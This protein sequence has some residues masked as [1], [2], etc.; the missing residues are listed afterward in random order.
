M[1]DKILERKKKSLQKHIDKTYSYYLTRFKP[2]FLKK[3]NF[4]GNDKDIE[5]RKLI[6]YKSIKLYAEAKTLKDLCKL[7]IQF[8]EKKIYCSSNPTGP[9]HDNLFPKNTWDEILNVDNINIT[10]QLI[11]INKLGIYTL[12]SQNGKKGIYEGVGYNYRM[13]VSGVTT[14]QIAKKIYKYFA[15]HEDT[16]VIS[17]N[18][19]VINKCSKQKIELSN[20]SIATDYEFDPI[21]KKICNTRTL[22]PI[23]ARFNHWDDWSVS[24]NEHLEKNSEKY[25]FISIVDMKY[26][27]NTLFGKI[28]DGLKY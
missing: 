19:S 10:N 21:T 8:F 11:N 13:F 22:I 20:I 12:N 2:D 7:N 1:T 4:L 24:F 6:L 23:T 25:A 16:V 5:D 3:L 27:R 9:F 26:N 28:I 14:T 18:Y 15:D 17:E